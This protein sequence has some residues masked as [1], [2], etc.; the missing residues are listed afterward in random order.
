MPLSPERVPRPLF[1]GTS[2]RNETQ[3]NLTVL[4]PFLRDFLL[5]LGH[6]N[7]NQDLQRRPYIFIIRG[8]D[9]AQT[10][11]A[12]LEPLGPRCKCPSPKSIQQHHI[13]NPTH[14]I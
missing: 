13:H 4:E 6:P 9:H 10:D 12:N 11:N 7:A 3:F 14:K 2:I 8:N 5:H 1:K